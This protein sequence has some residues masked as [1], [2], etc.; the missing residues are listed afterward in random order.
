MAVWIGF[1]SLAKAV[2][3]FVPREKK[4]RVYSRTKQDLS[5]YENTEWCSPE[6]FHKETT[7]VLFL[8]KQGIRSFMEDFNDTFSKG[9]T[10]YYTAT[11]MM[12]KD[13]D[14]LLPPGTKVVPW[15]WVTQADELA[16]SGKALAVT[17]SEE[18][19][20]RLGELFGKKIRTLAGKEEDV[21]TVNKTV[22]KAAIETAIRLR[23][24]LDAQGIDREIIEHAVRQIIPGVIRAYQ[25]G[26]LGGFGKQAAKELEN[27]ET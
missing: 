24:E 17:E 27:D 14:S 19:A 6:S 13:I 9:T 7:F 12:K 15:K 16:R 21:L 23:R 5:N 4:I 22:T 1:G 8:P 2:R 26:K 18:E 11:G 3:Q 25:D 20:A 10:F